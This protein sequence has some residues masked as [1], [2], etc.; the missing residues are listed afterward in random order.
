MSMS[1]AGREQEEKVLGMGSSLVLR[2]GSVLSGKWKGQGGLG[3]VYE[4]RV[5]QKR[6]YGERERP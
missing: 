4:E 6:G 3:G 5:V 1:W 2:K